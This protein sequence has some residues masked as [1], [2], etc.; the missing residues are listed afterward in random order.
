M[1]V[2][3]IALFPVEEDKLK[4]CVAITID[5]CFVVR[6]VKIIHTVNG[7]LISMPSKQRKDGTYKDLA[8]PINSEKGE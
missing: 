4:A 2:T 3:V 1:E 8:H 7:Y 5:N 6:D